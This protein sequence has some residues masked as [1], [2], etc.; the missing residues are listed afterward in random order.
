MQLRVKYFT[1]FFLWRGWLHLSN[2]TWEAIK[3]ILKT[4]IG[5]ELAFRKKISSDFKDST[6]LSTWL[7]ASFTF[8]ILKSEINQLDRG[9]LIYRDATVSATDFSFHLNWIIVLSFHRRAQE[10]KTPAVA[11]EPPGR[12][13]QERVC[14]I[15]VRGGRVESARS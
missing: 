15:R 12:N 7:Y 6:V 4:E 14:E 10:I 11:Q 8:W 9:S 13:D 1:I 2:M 5:S 3:I